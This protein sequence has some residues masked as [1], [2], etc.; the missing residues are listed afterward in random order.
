VHR[1][2]EIGV[3]GAEGR[4]GR[5]ICGLAARAGCVVTLAGRRGG[6]EVTARP[7]VV[8]DVSHRSALPSV[9]EFCNEKR[10]PLVEGTSGLTDE[11]LAAIRRLSKRVAV[12]RAPNFAFGSFLQ[13][14][15][16]SHLAGLMRGAP[17]CE[18]SI[19]DR[20]PS[21]KADRPSATAGE[22]A[23]LWAAGHGSA[24]RDVASVRGGLPV[25]DHSLTVTLQGETVTVHHGVGDRAAAA[26]GAL[27]AAHRLC[28]RP[29]CL[30]TMADVYSPEVAG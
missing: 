2:L 25:A 11:D 28:G 16:V 3:I 13:A 15:L 24:V 23:R 29:P 20:H 30:W 14:A 4:L 19:V 26:A 9:L 1:T 6:W 7:E 5:V 10:V 22:L 21:S 27:R 18:A 8:I 17:D 12:V